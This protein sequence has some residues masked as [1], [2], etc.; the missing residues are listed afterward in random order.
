MEERLLCLGLFSNFFGLRA[1]KALPVIIEPFHLSPR[2]QH[3]IGP[4]NLFLSVAVASP[5]AFCNL[6]PQR[7]CGR[8]PS[9]A[10]A[11]R[12]APGLKREQRERPGISDD[13]S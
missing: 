8:Q 7:F 10:D 3:G 12:T 1:L 9:G 11:M 6:L 2:R 13:A 5:K 4:A